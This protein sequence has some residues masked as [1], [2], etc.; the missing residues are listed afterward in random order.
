MQV[1]LQNAGPTGNWVKPPDFVHYT[2]KAGRNAVFIFSFPE[3]ASRPASKV[4][5]IYKKGC[6]H[7]CKEYALPIRQSLGTGLL[8]R[9]IKWGMD[10]K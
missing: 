4:D 2:H 3:I 6:I 9:S 8:S 7:V 5:S 10:E 1:N